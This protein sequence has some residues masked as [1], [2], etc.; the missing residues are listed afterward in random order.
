MTEVHAPQPTKVVNLLDA[1][2]ASVA[3]ARGR[4][5]GAEA[6]ETPTG[7][8]RAGGRRP[9]APRPASTKGL[10]KS[11]LYD[12]ATE[13]GIAGRSKMSRTELEAAVA[14]AS[15]PQRRRRAS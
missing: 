2:N 9:K 15:A 1:R 14:A 7:G 8:S 3:A 4:R 11:D 5:E 12:R 10:S 13:L 6:P